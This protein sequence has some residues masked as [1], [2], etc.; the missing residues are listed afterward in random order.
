MK[1]REIPLKVWSRHPSHA[2]LRKLLVS[3]KTVIR[4]G[5][6]LKRKNSSRQRRN[7]CK[8]SYHY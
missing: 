3:H 6:R 2:P 4:F 1:K 8:E 5:Y 7:N